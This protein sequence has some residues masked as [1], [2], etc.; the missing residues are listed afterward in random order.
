MNEA[1][2]ALAAQQAEYND[3]TIESTNIDFE[4]VLPVAGICVLRFREY[5]ELGLQPTASKTY[6]NKKPAIKALFGFELTLPKHS[7]VVGEGTENAYKRQ[8][9]IRITTSVSNSGKSNY[10]K[11]FRMLNWK[12]KAKVPAQLLGEAYK[13]TVYHSYDAKDLEGGKPKAGAKPAY[14]NLNAGVSNGDY[15]IQPPRKE[16]DPLDDTSVPIEI[17]VP[18]L[19]EPLKLFLWSFPTKETWDS[20]FID[21]SYEKEIDGKKVEK[22]KNWIQNLILSALDYQGSQLQEIVEGG[23]TLDLPMSEAESVGESKPEGR[24]AE[25]S[26]MDALLGV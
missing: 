3:Y 23:D 2:A 20:L 18:A 14:A 7:Y 9:F 25:E 5:I 10:M 4:K 19:T 17:K 15:S 24:S 21:G 12:G 13:A 22:S 11:I 1:L 26:E 6:P 16:A 8:H